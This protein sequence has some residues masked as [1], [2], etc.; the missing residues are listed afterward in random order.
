MIHWLGLGAF[1]SSIQSLVKG[2]GLHISHGADKT[3]IYIYTSQ[4]KIN[5]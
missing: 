4:K 5:T 3:H 2:L 1:T